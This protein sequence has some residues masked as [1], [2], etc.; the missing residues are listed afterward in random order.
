MAEHSSAGLRHGTDDVHDEASSRLESRGLR[1]T[2]GRRRLVEA[3]VRT[4]GPTTLPDLL[5]AEP[6]LNQ[7]SAYRNLVELVH[8]G[9]VL[10]V[11]SGGERA[12]F[13]L[14]EPLR[15]H[16]HHLV[17]RSCGTIAD[18][19][20]DD[21]LE[22]RLADAFDGLAAGESFEPDGHVIDIIGTCAGCRA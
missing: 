10:R 7:S 15:E 9:V 21:R 11:V 8:A 14:A 5:D 17:C 13:E 1:Y 22:A 16:H 19:A 12:H 3:L 6:G 4:G 2:T 20:F 18:V